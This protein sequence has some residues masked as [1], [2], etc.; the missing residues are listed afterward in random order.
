MKAATVRRKSNHGLV[1]YQ[2]LAGNMFAYNVVRRIRV[3]LATSTLV[4]AAVQFPK[5]HTHSARLLRPACQFCVFRTMVLA[6]A[7]KIPA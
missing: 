4:V 5:Q 2:Q 1:F 7:N 3:H 6:T